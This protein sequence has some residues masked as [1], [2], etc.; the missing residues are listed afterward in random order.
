MMYQ[1]RNPNIAKEPEVIQ[2]NGKNRIPQTDMKSK[3]A[4]HDRKVIIRIETGTVTRY[5]G[6][7]MYILV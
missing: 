5:Y 4:F 6:E 2:E 3:I 7:L 1:V